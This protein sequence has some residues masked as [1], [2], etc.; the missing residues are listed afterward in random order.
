MSQPDFDPIET[1][2]LGHAGAAGGQY[3]DSIGKSDLEKLTP[4]EWTHFLELVVDGF[5]CRMRERLCAPHVPA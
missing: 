2:A 5:G 4:N 3:L 1:D